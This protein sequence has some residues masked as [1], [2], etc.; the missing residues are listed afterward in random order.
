MRFKIKVNFEL[1]FISSSYL[2]L[3]CL[4]NKMCEGRYTLCVSLSVPQKK[5]C[6]MKT[7]PNMIN[8]IKQRQ[9]PRN[10]T[11]QFSSASR[12]YQINLFFLKPNVMILPFILHGFGTIMRRLK[13]TGPWQCFFDCLRLQNYLNERT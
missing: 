4:L 2:S 5:M 11:P 1:V 10:K 7:K 6:E 3:S 9:T 12:S 8:A 13:S